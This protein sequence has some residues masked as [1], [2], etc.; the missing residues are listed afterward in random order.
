MRSSRATS[1]TPPA[2]Y[3][4][5]ACQRPQGFMSAMIG[6]RAEMRSKSSIVK[7]IPKSR[8]IATRWSTALVEPPVA[9]T[10]ATAFSNDSLVTNDRGVRFS[11]TTR[12]ASRPSSYAASSF[13]R[14]IAGMPF[15]PNGDSP[16][17][18]RIVDIVLAVNWPPHA[19]APGHA[20]DSSSCRSASL[21]LPAACAPM[22]S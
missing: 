15:V 12:T 2:A 17:K 21:S 6:V 18:S 16:R 3:M 8:A 5:F 4:S 14:C 7:S 13:A 9:A 11:R 20:T 19:P 22:P 10:D 1:A